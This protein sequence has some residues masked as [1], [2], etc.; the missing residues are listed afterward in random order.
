[1]LTIGAPAA[2][3]VTGDPLG[4][5]RWADQQPSIAAVWFIDHLQ[6]WFPRGIESGEIGDPHALGDPFALMAA[7][8]AQTQRVA[9]GVSVSDPFRRAPA[10]LAQSAMTISW[11]GGRP[12]ILGLGT[13]VAENLRPFG[14]EEP[15]PVAVVEEACETLTAFRSGPEARSGGGPRWPRMDASLGIS[16]MSGFGLWVGALGP[17][18]LE[19]TGHYGDGWVPSMLSPKAYSGKLEQIRVSAEKHGRDPDRI[20]PAMFV[21]AALGHSEPESLELLSAP[22]V[23]ATALYRSQSAYAKHSAKHPL[24]GGEFPE[25]LPGSIATP[26]ARRIVD[27]IPLE[28]AKES[29]LCGSI[30]DVLSR[31][32]Q[33]EEAGARHII[34]YDIGRYVG[35]G[36]LDR[37]RE[38]LI[39]LARG[40]ADS[41]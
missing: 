38:C 9:I 5:V 2:V 13:G 24:G 36:G 25:Y 20:V 8:A 12:M 18:M 35:A 14:L 40:R 32:D 16:A 41:V 30:R 23:R 39:E 21:W 29:I 33:F 11:L 17:R 3:H 28:V 19:I 22:F 31:L 4:D 15:R 27:S 34:V 1:M 6:G 26:E 10:V 7:A 37:S